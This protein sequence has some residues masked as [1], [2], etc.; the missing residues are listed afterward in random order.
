MKRTLLVVA[1]LGL[2]LATGVQAQKMAIGPSILWKGGV[3]VG[4]IPTGA[5]TG[6]NIN[7]IPDFAATFRMLLNTDESVGFTAD[8][9]YAQY[10][11]RMRP[12]SEALAND[13]N[14]FIYKRSYLNIAPMLFLSGFQIGASFGF[15]LSYS[16]MNVSG[17]TEA[18]ITSKQTSPTI[19]VRIGGM[20]PVLRNKSGRLNFLVHAGYMLTGMNDTSGLSTSE[21]T[22]N[23]KTASF[24]LG[25]NY[26]FNLGD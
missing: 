18:D 7:P 13:N 24:G 17:S 10:T 1:L 14:T 8:L 25:V 16:L 6:V 11:F 22:Y 21:T 19:E 26:L 5:K 15:P 2:L 3:N 12:E 9:G 23:P 20:I 4:N